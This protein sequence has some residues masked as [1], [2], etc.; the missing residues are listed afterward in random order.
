[1]QP[2]MK[3]KQ[4]EIVKKKNKLGRRYLTPRSRF[5]ATSE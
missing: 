2:K 5:M 1:M 4:L 3:K